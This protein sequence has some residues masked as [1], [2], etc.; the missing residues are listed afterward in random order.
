MKSV[1]KEPG[2][3]GR[4]PGLFC[5]KGTDKSHLSGVVINGRWCRFLNSE[6][7]ILIHN[8]RHDT[9][10]PEPVHHHVMALTQII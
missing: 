3:S 10:T 9:V 8:S 4:G 1:E 2:F 5:F 7:I 6:L